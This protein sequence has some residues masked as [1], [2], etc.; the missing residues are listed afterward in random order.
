ME[1]VA[2]SLQKKIPIRLPQIKRI[3]K[4]I[5]KEKNISRGEFS[6][7]FVTDQRIKFLNKKFLH[8]NYSTDVLAFER[9]WENKK[10]E[11]RG[12]VVISID[13]AR[14]NARRFKTSL[15]YEIVLYV[16]HG[17][18]HLSGFDDHKPTDI[19]KMRREEQK[20]MNHLGNQIKNII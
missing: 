15:A 11:I 6:L 20:L 12:D 18:L 5:L 8:R 7:V 9:R 2:E 13:A 14:K 10:R 17:I 4:A 16:V 3:V 1:I 19:K